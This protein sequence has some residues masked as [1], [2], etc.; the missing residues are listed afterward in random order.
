MSQSIDN[1]QE[2]F[3]IL[4]VAVDASDSGRALQASQNY[5]RI[6]VPRLSVDTKV[7]ISAI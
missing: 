4:P 3:S 5:F 7:L 6:E 1:L 2:K